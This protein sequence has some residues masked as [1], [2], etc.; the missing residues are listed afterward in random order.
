MHARSHART[1]GIGIGPVVAAA[2]TS[3]KLM[4]ENEIVTAACSDASILQPTLL[5]IGV[6][7]QPA[8]VR[9]AARLRARAGAAGAASVADRT[10]SI[11]PKPIRLFAFCGALLA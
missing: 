7:R 10:G 6:R 5:R 4:S 3:L 11:Q 9:E 8:H 1:A 2:G